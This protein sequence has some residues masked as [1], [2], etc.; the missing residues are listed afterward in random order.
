[1][2]EGQA[3]KVLALSEEV[4]AT[5]GYFLEGGSVLFRGVGLEKLPMSL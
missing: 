2:N 3:L 5:D 4:L 1:M